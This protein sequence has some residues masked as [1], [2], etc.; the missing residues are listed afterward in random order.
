MKEQLHRLHFHG[1]IQLKSGHNTVE[2]GGGTENHSEYQK[3]TLSA[4]YSNARMTIVKSL[5]SSQLQGVKTQSE[6]PPP[7]L[8]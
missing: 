1:N 8:S 3:T 6:S 4:E 2:I 7:L 5:L